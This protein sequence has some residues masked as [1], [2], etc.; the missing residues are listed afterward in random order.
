MF[1]LEMH[2]ELRLPRPVGVDWLRQMGTK[3]LA[4]LQRGK[5]VW[6]IIGDYIQCAEVTNS[7]NRCELST[8]PLLHGTQVHFIRRNDRITTV[9]S[10]HFIADGQESGLYR[11]VDLHAAE[12]YYER[13]FSQTEGGEANLK[14]VA[15]GGGSG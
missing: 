12:E 9:S 6:L 1:K 4:Q 2:K 5:F 3:K 8:R 13:I 10:P 11:I 7:S 14:L 15:G